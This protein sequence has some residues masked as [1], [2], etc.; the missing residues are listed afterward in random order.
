MPRAFQTLW[1]PGSETGVRITKVWGA[2]M[3]ATNAW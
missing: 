2:I 3:W 1:D